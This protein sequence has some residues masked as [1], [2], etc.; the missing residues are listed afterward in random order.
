MNLA[1][2]N[3]R[4]ILP[5]EKLFTLFDI[6]IKLDIVA[7][8]KLYEIVCRQVLNFSK[9]YK[10]TD[11]NKFAGEAFSSKKKIKELCERFNLPMTLLQWKRASDLNFKAGENQEDEKLLNYYW[12][13]YKGAMTALRDRLEDEL[14]IQLAFWIPSENHKYLKNQFS[15]I[16]VDTFDDLASDMEEVCNC[17]LFERHTATAFHLMR[18][19]EGSV[20]AV[21]VHLGIEYNNSSW[22]H[23]IEKL[24]D[25][26]DDLPKTEMNKANELREIIIS[27]ELIKN[28]W[29]NRIVHIDTKYDAG[30]AKKI[31]DSTNRL[32]T[33]I[34]NFLKK[35]K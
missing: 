20:K 6:V 16:A 23:I 25:K 27:V 13:E 29:R 8:A 1:Y 17:M 28:A 4:R 34:A 32:I 18:I 24:K 31:I 15:Q 19:C 5:N 3:N 35:Y 21:T 7:L 10:P 11:Y 2:K 14:R 22:A 33:E 9:E 30:E 26:A 12:D